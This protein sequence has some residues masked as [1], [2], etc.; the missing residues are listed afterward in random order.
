MYSTNDITGDAIVS[1]PNSKAYEDNFDRI[2][3]KKDK[4]CQVCGKDTSSTK[5]CAWTS[6]PLN[7]DEPK[8]TSLDAAY[9]RRAMEEGLVKEPVFQENAEWNEKRMDIISSNGNEGL[10]YDK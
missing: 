4:L 6:C 8:A 1:R 10:H 5:E 7:W 2:F 3:G 9:E